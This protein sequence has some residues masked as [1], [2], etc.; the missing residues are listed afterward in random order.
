MTEFSWDSNPPDPKGVPMAL[1]ARWVSQALYQSWSTGVTAF[2][3]FLVRDQPFTPTSYYQSGLY[4]INESSPD[5][6][7]LDKAKPAL[8]AFRFPFVA[9]PQAKDNI[10]V[11]GRTPD[12]TAGRVQIQRKSGSTWKLVKTLN[13]NSY[14]IFRARITRPAKTTFLRARLADGS[15][16][17]VPFSLVAPKKTWH[18]CAFGSGCYQ[19]TPAGK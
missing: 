15:D 16:I 8:T 9:F 18:N 19:N 13:A 10:T 6:L 2:I 11:W 1:E 3:W 5:D 12:S 14:G 17:S 4:T 7:T